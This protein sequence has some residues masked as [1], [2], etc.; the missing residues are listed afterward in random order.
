MKNLRKGFSNILV[1]VFLVG[2]AVLMIAI[3]S[4]Q[5]LRS[6]GP[7]SS[8]IP[9]TVGVQVSPLSTTVGSSVPL[10][11]IGASIQL[12]MSGP[13][14]LV[15]QSSGKFVSIAGERGTVL[16]DPASGVTRTLANTALTNAHVSDHWLVYEDQPPL[17][18]T[19]YFSR[20][21]A[22]DLNTGKQTFLGNENSSQ[23]DP[24][25]SGDVVVWDE[26]HN[27]HKT[28]VYAYDLVASKT[29]SVAIGEGIRGYPQISGQWIVYLQWPGQHPTGKEEQVELHV[30][31]L[32][33]DEDLLV[34]LMPMTIDSW[35]LSRYA[36][37]GDKLA[38]VKRTPDGQF[39]IHLFDLT[40]KI[41]RKLI[42]PE[43]WPLAGISL[44]AKNGIIV[45]N[46]DGRRVALDWLQTTPT[47][48]SLTLPTKVQWGYELSVIDDYLV[49]RIPLNR[50]SSDVQIFAAKILR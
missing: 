36:L 9:T 44:S 26:A 14:G 24:Q 3:L 28:N 4:S 7:G 33:T 1:L 25:I 2:L 32:A 35:G 39:E 21:K 5:S 30:R 40:S 18:S 27:G 15:N 22:V 12:Q 38:W 10:A 20:I 19:T 16:F 37:D 17:G 49:W 46:N 34:G 42:G 11:R 29:F 45:Y 41:D 31:S 43:K 47:P 6:A 50:E 23:Q 13:L 48:L 8:P